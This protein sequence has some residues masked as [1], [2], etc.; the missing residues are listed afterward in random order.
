M[1]Q[2]MHLS[3]YVHLVSMLMY[4]ACS[5][6]TSDNKYLRNWLTVQYSA[7]LF[8]RFCPSVRC[9]YCV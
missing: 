9:Q 6:D 8:Y 1:S 4:D 2:S 7:M 5:S 3:S